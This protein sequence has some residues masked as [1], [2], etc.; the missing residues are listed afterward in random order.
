MGGPLHKAALSTF[1]IANAQGLFKGAHEGHMLGTLAI[2]KV[3]RAALCK[4]PPMG[5]RRARLGMD[6]SV[7]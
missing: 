7:R 5:I 4:G 1:D 3:L 2:S 6:R